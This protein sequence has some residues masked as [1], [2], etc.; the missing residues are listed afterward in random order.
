[1][2]VEKLV[3]GKLQKPPYLY[4]L[5][6]VFLIVVVLMNLL[7]GLAVSDTGV[8]RAEAEVY[9]YK[10]QVEIIS[11]LEST[12]LGDPFN[13]LA[14]W[15]TFVW[16]R[17]VPSCSIIGDGR[18]YRVPQIRKLFHRVTR[19]KNIMLFQ[20]SSSSMDPDRHPNGYAATFLPN[21]DNGNWEFLC[22]CCCCSSASQEDT[23]EQGYK[24]E[25]LP[26]LVAESA[27]DKVHDTLQ[28]RL[29]EAEKNQL[30]SRLARMENLLYNLLE[31]MS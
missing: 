24:I 3:T 30:E 8:I 2:L 14:N 1:M 22:S 28:K 4:L 25:D 7:N 16:L 26:S 19:A 23:S 15:P 12:I 13:F 21:Q 6:F 29:A 27:K 31:K 20:G 17:K 10:T 11:Y 18:L 5:A 9:A